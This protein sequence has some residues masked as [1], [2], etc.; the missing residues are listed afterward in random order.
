MLCVIVVNCSGYIP[1][2]IF[3]MKK[4]RGLLIWIFSLNN[5]TQSCIASSEYGYRTRL[6]PEEPAI[7]ALL[8]PD[9]HLL[10]IRVKVSKPK[11]TRKMVTITH[12]HIRT[13]K[14][15]RL[16]DEEEGWNCALYS[17]SRREPPHKYF[18][19]YYVMANVQCWESGSLCFW[20]TR[21]RIRIL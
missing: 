11:Y 10:K 16:S 5:K 12:Y 14:N 19:N 21:I 17:R 6:S 18:S 20:A 1:Y 7:R 13:S 4:S 8:W 3:I 2:S 15:R 9:L